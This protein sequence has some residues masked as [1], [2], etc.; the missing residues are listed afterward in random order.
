MEPNNSSTAE[1]GDTG[2]AAADTRERLE[3]MEHRDIFVTRTL[4]LVGGVLTPCH[5]FRSSR[6]SG[7]RRFDFGSRPRSFFV[8]VALRDYKV[9]VPYRLFH[10]GKV[11]TRSR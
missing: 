9:R 1:R 6:P 7:V 8:Y 3:E 5:L 2:N 4:D 10:Q 11:Q